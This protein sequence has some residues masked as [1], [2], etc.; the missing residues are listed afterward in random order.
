MDVQL[1]EELARFRRY[2]AGRPL[3]ATHT[4]RFQVSQPNPNLGF[5]TAWGDRFTPASATVEAPAIPQA[6]RPVLAIAAADPSEAAIVK[7]TDASANGSATKGDAPAPDAEGNGSDAYTDYF[8]STQ[9][10]LDAL[11]ER[12]RTEPEEN[13]SLADSLLTPLGIGSLLLFL[14]AGGTLGYA[15][16]NPDL[17]PLAQWFSRNEPTSEPKVSAT[18][19]GAVP[20]I[21]KSPN[22]ATQEFVPL[23]LNS[24]SVIKPVTDNPAPIN[25][26]TPTPLPTQS[27]AQP[28]PPTQPSNPPTPGTQDN[29]NN[30]R[31]AILPS[32]DP[33]VVE[34]L[35]EDFFYV[36]LP[37]NNPQN[38]A[39]ARQLVPEAYARKFP[40][41]IAYR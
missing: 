12:D 23:D 41:A 38:L 31:S 35:V 36:V 21:P 1:Q 26:I 30:L 18:A 5:A 27:P 16:F 39:R 20:S 19:P 17:L 25:N 37:Y 8:A 3:P 22:L 7:P 29:L 34:P 6:S 2:R 13:T 32:S 11:E 14:L 10:L 40:L 24:L 15:L 33:A 28:S 9:D 4:T